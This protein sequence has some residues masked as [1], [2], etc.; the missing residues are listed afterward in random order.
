MKVW[1]KPSLP[2]LNNLSRHEP[3]KK[4][5]FGIKNISYEYI[6]MSLSALADNMNV[7]APS[8]LTYAG[9]WSATQNYVKN[10]LVVGSNGSAYVL[11]VA[12]NTGTDPVGAPAPSPWVAL[13][14]GGGG[15]GG[16][17]MNLNP[18]NNTS[19]SGDWDANS[20]Y[21]VGDVVRDGSATAGVGGSLWICNTVV[22]PAVAP[23]LNTSPSTL[24]NDPVPWTP[25]TPAL[26]AGA[27]INLTPLGNSV[28]IAS[29]GGGGGLKLITSGTALTAKVAG[30]TPVGNSLSVPLQQFNL[31]LTAGNTYLLTLMY[32]GGA[33]TTWSGSSSGSSLTSAPYISNTAAGLED[34]LPSLFGYGQQDTF[35]APTAVSAVSNGANPLIDL[36]PIT[37]T[38]FY[39]ALD[40]NVYLNIQL[41]GRAGD[42]S[43][44]NITW[45]DYQ[46]GW[47][48][49]MSAVDLGA[50]PP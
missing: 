44:A 30:G 10:N 29:V 28:T 41:T 16:G 7:F 40:A 18:L 27:G 39:P 11:Q 21:A 22:P 32:D 45:T 33:N 36:P 25:L 31:G 19:G 35:S 49:W 47:R 8:A 1:L 15:G 37:Y 26:T 6:T 23:A 5:H 20:G 3:L 38:V 14:G 48:V 4:E 9:T 50:T 2:I 24:G 43:V 46:P 13:A 17:N 12:S 42:P 34:S